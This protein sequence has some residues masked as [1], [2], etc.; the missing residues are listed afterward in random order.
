[1]IEAQHPR[2]GKLLDQTPDLQVQGLIRLYD[3]GL[4]FWGLGVQG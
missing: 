4:G 3:F 2:E 1:M